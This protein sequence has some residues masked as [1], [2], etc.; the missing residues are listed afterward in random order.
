MLSVVFSESGRRLCFFAQGHAGYALKG[1]DIICAAASILAQTLLENLREAEKRGAGVLEK[2]VLNQGLACICFRK[3]R[4]D[5]R[6]KQI[7]RTI[8]TGFLLLGEA[9]EGAVV[10]E[11]RNRVKRAGA[12]HWEEGV[13]R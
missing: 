3:K 4:R 10:V 11:G 1:S 7:F 9:A 2:S 12:A 13:K 5:R 8:R 6:A